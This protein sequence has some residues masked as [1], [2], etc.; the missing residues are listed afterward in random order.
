LGLAVIQDKI[1]A[2]AIHVALG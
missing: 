1:V 2:L